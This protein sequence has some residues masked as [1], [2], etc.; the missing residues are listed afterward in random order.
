MRA[1]NCG[2]RT[3]KAITHNSVP[4]TLINILLHMFNKCI[5]IFIHLIEFLDASF[6][7]HARPGVGMPRCSDA[8]CTTRT[9]YSVQYSKKS[10]KHSTKSM[11]ITARSI[12]S[13]DVT[14]ILAEVD[15]AIIQCWRQQEWCVPQQTC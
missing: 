5:P 6:F 3:L 1:K 8:C 11:R 14:H 4:N 12:I 9:S 2:L 13:G 7:H 15:I 10:I